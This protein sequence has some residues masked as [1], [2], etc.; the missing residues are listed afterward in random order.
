VVVDSTDL[1]R[2]QV[3]DRVVELARTAGEVRS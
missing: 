2:E 1:G 3:V